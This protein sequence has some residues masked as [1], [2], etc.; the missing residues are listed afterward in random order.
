MRQTQACPKFL[1]VVFV[2]YGG[3]LACDGYVGQFLHMYY[4]IFR[5][6]LAVTHEALVGMLLRCSLRQSLLLVGKVVSRTSLSTDCLMI[7][8]M[9]SK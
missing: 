4:S 6:F 7:V 3:Y 8:M 5:K 2:L 9:Q 1:F